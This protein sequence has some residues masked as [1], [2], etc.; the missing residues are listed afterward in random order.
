MWLACLDECEME[1]KAMGA[2]M[3]DSL[4]EAEAQKQL[5]MPIHEQSEQQLNS[6]YAS[7]KILKQVSHAGCC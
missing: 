2:A 4:L 5:E 1:S 7:S 6:R 3:Q